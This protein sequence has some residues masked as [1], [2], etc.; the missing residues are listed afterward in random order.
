MSKFLR[1]QKGFTLIE[2]LVVVII[3][4]ILAAMAVPVYMR[5]VEKARSTE[6]QSAIRSIRGAYDLYK[7]QYGSTRNYDIEQ[8][9]KDVN[10]GEATRKN[11]EFEVVGD[12]PQRFVA[13]STADFAGGEGHQVLYDVEEAKFHGYGIDTFTDDEESE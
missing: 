3:V 9:L 12:P 11:W 4:A 8:A 10:V 1:N 7:Q 2:I 5:Y 13:T 6:A